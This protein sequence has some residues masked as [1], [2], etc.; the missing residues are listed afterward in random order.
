[1]KTKEDI[2]NKENNK[3]KLL[4]EYKNMSK[5]ARKE[6]DIAMTI[7]NI[8]EIE[9]SLIYKKKYYLNLERENISL[10]KE[11]SGVEN[12]VKILE[13]KEQKYIFNEK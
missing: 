1:M 10:M 13:G 12:K 2:N 3:D 7:N 4:N 5:E 6:L 11:K 9:S 8:N